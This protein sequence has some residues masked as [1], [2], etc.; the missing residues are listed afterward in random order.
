[1]LPY[2]WDWEY[3]KRNVRQLKSYLLSKLRHHKYVLP[4][5]KRQRKMDILNMNKF[6]YLVF[7]RLK[8]ETHESH[9]LK[10]KTDFFALKFEG[11]RSKFNTISNDFEGSTNSEIQD[12][13][14]YIGVVD[15]R[16]LKIRR[17]QRVFI[18][19]FKTFLI[20]GSTYFVTVY[21]ENFIR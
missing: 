8:N 6:Q 21:F 15:P 3:Y 19:S 10:Q 9:T 20:L 7:F 17:Y 12:K 13:H 14:S 2:R 4:C 5:S 1:M 16:I 18:G 11:N